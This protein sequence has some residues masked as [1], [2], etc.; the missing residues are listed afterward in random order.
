MRFQFDLLDNLRRF[1][2]V[3]ALRFCRAERDAVYP[4]CQL[5]RHVHLQNRRMIA[6]ADH[7]EVPVAEGIEAVAEYRWTQEL[8]RAEHVD[9]FVRDD[10]SRQQH[11]VSRFRA[12]SMHAFARG[13]VVGFDLVSFIAYDE[14]GIPHREL[15]LK[16]PSGFVVD[17]RD[18][19]SRCRNLSQILDFLGF[20]AI[21]YGQRILEARELA[22]FL[23]PDT[24]NG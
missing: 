10:R 21:H 9:R 3:E 4:P 5:V 23:L 17:D 13:D 2:Q 7:V 19:K 8:I 14:I 20:T 24:E 11:P 15:F 1:R 6:V 12:E 22:K 18:L 16:P